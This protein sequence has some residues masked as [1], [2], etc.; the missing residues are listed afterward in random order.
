MSKAFASAA[1]TVAK[2]IT[3]D[4]LAEGVYAFTAEG[5][6]NSGV[7][8]GD[9][10]VMVIDTQATPVMAGEVLE[11]IR[12]VTPKPVKYVVL[13]HYHAVRV[14]GAAAYGAQHIIASQPTLE[15]IRERGAQ[16]FKSEADRF[17]RLFQSI[18][19][20]PGL[21]WPTLV[22]DRALTV[23]MGKREVRIMHLGRGHTKGDTVVWLPKE[24]VL[25]S[26]DLVEMGAAPYCGDAYLSEWPRT[27][28]AVRALKPRRLVPGRGAALTSAAKSQAAIDGTA[29]FLEALMR[30]V[31]RG[32]AR[33]DDLRRTY[34]ATHRSMVKRYGDWVIFEHCMPFNVARA[35]DEASGIADP[36]IWTAARDKRMWR[37]LQG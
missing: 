31:R 6:P 7:V 3:F 34:A 11:R 30:Q 14:L 4:R 28:A 25:F 18:E 15:L 10:G 26:G 23:W 13:S 8:I 5:D 21:T 24:K 29:A 35:Y 17:P 9:D 32:V 33:K 16:D 22:F 20:I 37:S 12:R 19:S 27:L 36:R 1:D 2:K